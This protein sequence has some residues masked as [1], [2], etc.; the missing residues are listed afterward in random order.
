MITLYFLE[1]ADPLTNFGIKAGFKYNGK[2]YISLVTS[3][4]GK[5]FVTTGAKATHDFTRHE[6]SPEQAAAVEA[7]KESPEYAVELFAN[8]VR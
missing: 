2:R 1:V 3:Q 8:P 5:Y 7:F 4:N 6:L